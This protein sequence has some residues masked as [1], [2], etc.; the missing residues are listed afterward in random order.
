MTHLLLADHYHRL[1][2]EALPLIERQGFDFD[3]LLDSS[4][5][6]RFG[7]TLLIRPGEEVKA[8]IQEFIEEV[9]KADPNQY[10]YP[11]SD[12]H[13]TV[14]PIISC[15]EGFQIK[16]I[17][18]EEYINLLKECLREIPSFNID[19]QG[20]T[21][22]PSCLMV[23]GF[24]SDLNLENIRNRLRLAFR[25]ADL[26][27]SLD[28]RYPLQTAHA[29]VVRFRNKVK[30]PSRILQIIDQW[31]DHDFGTSKVFSLELVFNDWYQRKQKVDHLF[32][33]NLE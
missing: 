2:Q 6:Q 10:F 20:I 25:Q 8:S 18:I 14:M 17:K 3:P 7:I 1:W 23:K 11:N 16:N 24:P 13:I 30:D 12:I 22:S 27:Q 31:K 9:R 19:C 15:Y 4:K 28:K 33:F 5:D 21:A 32:T 26:E 29:T